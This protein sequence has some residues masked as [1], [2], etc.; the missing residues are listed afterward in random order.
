MIQQQER[1]LKEQYGTEISISTAKQKGRITFEFGS[2]DEF[3]ALIRQ[4][5]HK[6][7]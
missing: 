2:E 6:Y 1:Q 7:R 5:N 3:K 4:L